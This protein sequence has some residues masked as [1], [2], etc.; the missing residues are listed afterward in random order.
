MKR[1]LVYEYLV[2]DIIDKD[3]SVNTA[4][5]TQKLNKYGAEGWHLVS[6]YSNELG[7]N[8]ISI[9]GFGLNST[10]DQNILILERAI[11]E[12]EESFQRKIEYEKI[13]KEKLLEK[14]KEQNNKN[15]EIINEYI[16]IQLEKTDKSE[17]YKFQ[18]MYYGTS[19]LSF[20]KSILPDV[21]SFDDIDTYKEALKKCMK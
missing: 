9:A 11:E 7:K 13:E 8:T 19:A 2:I 4:E 5:L 15:D 12:D 20:M 18:E 6:A 3:G 14:Q 21:T 10:A 16:Q 1:K 17:I